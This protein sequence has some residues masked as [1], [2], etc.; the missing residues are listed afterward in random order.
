[1]TNHN[2]P[3]PRLQRRIDQ[4]TREK[5]ELQRKIEVYFEQQDSLQ[6]PERKI[7]AVLNFFGEEMVEG[8]LEV[9]IFDGIA[10][11][12]IEAC[13]GDFQCELVKAKEGWKFILVL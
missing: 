11:S 6:V 3:K 5:R 9:E 1:M 8:R 13:H 4:L 2:T 10:N 12:L 7:M